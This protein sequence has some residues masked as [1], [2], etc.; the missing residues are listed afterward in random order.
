MSAANLA[1]LIVERGSAQPELRLGTAE[2]QISL[3]QAI[4]FA[5]ARAWDLLDEGLQPGA[6]AALVGSTSTDYIVTW[7]ACLLA[8]APVAL[9]NP[10]YPED[11]RQR[12]LEPVAPQ[13]TL[14]ASE[15]A[16]ARCGSADVAGLPGL[17]AA[18]DATASYMHTSGTTG[19]PKFCVQ[20]HEYFRLMA[21]AVATALGLRPSDRVLAPL[22]LFHINPLGYGVVTSLLVGADVL[23]LERFSARRFWPTVVEERIT[24]M[25]LHAPPVEILKRATAP[26]DAAGHRIRNM[27]FADR[28]FMRRFSIP[29]AVSG[30]GSTEAGGLSHLH[31]WDSAQD[32]PDNASRHGGQPRPDFAWRL[33]E[34]GV[35]LLRE[36]EP[37]ALF[38]GYVTAGGVDSARDPDGWFATGDIGRQGEDPDYLVFVGRAAESIRVRGEYVP[39]DFVEGKLGEV[40]GLVDHAVWKRRGELVDDEVVLYAVG[41][42]LPTDVIRSRIDELPRFMRPVAIARVSALPRDAAVGKVQR[43]LLDEQ[44]VLDWIEL[45]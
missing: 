12:M 3:E 4:G 7:L 20:T 2:D 25:I 18:A 22:P 45:Q 30:Y 36:R 19:L 13:L 14:L 21:G 8:G 9:V 26:Q 27:F 43:R 29:A 38:G 28:E 37:S 44:P 23:G 33:N 5:A 1:R 10:T 32:M 24:V 31:R 35:I 17:D 39:I 16:D 40:G 15:I 42:P 11:L 6:P 41:D 34:D